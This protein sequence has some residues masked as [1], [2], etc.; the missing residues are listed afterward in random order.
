MTLSQIPD[1]LLTAVLAANF[2]PASLANRAADAGLRLDAQCP[3]LIARV[4]R[5]LRRR[6]ALDRR[7]TGYLDR[8][9]ASRLAEVREA[10]LDLL[11]TWAAAADWQRCRDFGGVLWAYC[12]DERPEV[13]AATRVLIRRLLQHALAPRCRG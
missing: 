3:Q 7:L 4:Q 10:D 1:E 12:R 2:D 8:V 6:P 13:R 5:E 11:R 9:H